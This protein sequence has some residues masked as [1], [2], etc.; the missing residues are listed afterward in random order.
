LAS[1]LV[2]LWYPLVSSFLFF[3]LDFCVFWSILSL[4]KYEER[5]SQSLALVNGLCPY[6][7][8]TFYLLIFISMK[9]KAIIKNTIKTADPSWFTKAINGSLQ[10]YI[11]A[12][13]DNAEYSIATLENQYNE[14][15]TKSNLT[16]WGWKDSKTGKFFLDLGFSVSSLRE[17]TLLGNLY[18]QKAIRD[19]A[20][21]QEIR[22]IA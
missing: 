17:A 16:V 5:W 11:I 22:L 1:Q 10:R 21:C 12:F 4:S 20:N 15:P 3:L 7:F 9:F 6:Q 19:N 14:W 8:K 13:T 18:N 2:I